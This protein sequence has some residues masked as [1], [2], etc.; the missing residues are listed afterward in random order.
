[1][2]P[3]GQHR[4]GV[5]IRPQVLVGFLNADEALNGAAVQH[6]LIVQRPF[7]LRGGDGHVFH[8]TEDVCELHPNELDILVAYHAEDV[9][10]AVP[11][12]LTV[13]FRLEACDFSFHFV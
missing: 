3:P 10:L 12:H 1:M 8:L 6:D 11:A 9:F 5:Q 4:E 13:S 2:G 7:D